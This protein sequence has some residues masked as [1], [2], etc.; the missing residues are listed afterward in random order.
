MSRV[1]MSCNLVRHFHGLH[2]QSTSRGFDPTF[3]QTVDRAAV[4]KHV[5][6][7]V[8]VAKH[9]GEWLSGTAYWPKDVGFTAA[10]K[11]TAGPAESSGGLSPGL[12]WLSYGRA[13][14]RD[15]QSGLNC[16]DMCR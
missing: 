13:D 11:V 8:S 14:C 10:G 15:R 7:Y 16:F 4:H 2:F 1:F 6:T 9:G 3:V 5:Q 12:L